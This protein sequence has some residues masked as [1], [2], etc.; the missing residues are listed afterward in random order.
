[1]H[2]SMRRFSIFATA[3]L[4]VAHGSHGVNFW[5]APAAALATVAHAEVP[6][7]S[8]RES[9]NRDVTPLLAAVANGDAAR[10]RE[11]LEAG[12]NPD[13]PAAGRSPLIQAITSFNPR[14]SSVLRCNTKLVK[15]L[16]SY[17]ADPNRPDPR[18]GATP[19]MTAFDIGD[20]QC[21][22]IIKD[23][24]GQTNAQEAG[25][26]TLLM[27]AV[28]AAARS[29]DMKIVDL[30]IAWGSNPNERTSGGM[31]ALHEAVRVNSAKVAEALL[32]RGAD[33][34][35]RNGLG[36]TPLDMAISLKRS[37][38]LIG[39]LRGVTRCTKKGKAN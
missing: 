27:C 4:F 13:D 10:V 3:V 14:V 28:G 36:Q 21:A 12:A 23:A 35:I 37:E 22:R 8:R 33:P 16:L 20:V 5:S 30:A 29:G 1:M 7:L 32:T 6:R 11:L 17:G 25:G 15:L 19:L 9:Q 18:T 26:R 38:F 39:V 2:R 34:C 31:T 24:G